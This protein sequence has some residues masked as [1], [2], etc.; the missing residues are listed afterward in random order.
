MIHAET[1]WLLLDTWSVRIREAI[2]HGFSSCETVGNR[3]LAEL[4][5]CPVCRNRVWARATKA[6]D[7]VKFNS[8]RIGDLSNMSPETLVVTDRFRDAWLHKGLKGLTFSSHELNCRLPARSITPSKTFFFAYPQPVFS[9]FSSREQIELAHEPSCQTCSSVEVRAAFDPRFSTVS[10]DALDC[11][12][13]SCMPGWVV[14]SKQAFEMVQTQGLLN[15][16]VMRGFAWT[17]KRD[18][19]RIGYELQTVDGKHEHRSSF[20]PSI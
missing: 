15:F 12:L 8:K 5:H 20:V 17:G 7:A 9:S 13:P 10:V 11:F 3:D 14:V 16:S 1:K 19:E 6:A 2:E 18:L 4:P